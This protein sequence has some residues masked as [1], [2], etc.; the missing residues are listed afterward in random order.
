MARDD[1]RGPRARWASRSCSSSTTWASSWASPTGSPSSTS[2]RASPTARRREVQTRPRGDPGL[3]RLRRVRVRRRPPQEGAHVTQFVELL[4]NGLSLGVDL[5]AHR[6]RL[7]DHLQGHAGGQLRAGLARAARRL[8]RSRAL[9]DRSASG[10]AVAGRHRRRRRS[11]RCSSSALI[12]RRLRG[13]AG[14]HA[15]DRH[16][17]RRHHPRHRAD[18]PDRH[19][20]AEHR[21][22][23]GR[24][25]RHGRRLSDPAGALVARRSAAI[26]ILGAFLAAFKYSDWGIAMRA[27]AEDGEAAAL[28]GIRL[29]R[30]AAA[31]L[32]ARG[33][34]RRG[35]R[36]C[37]SSALPDPGRRPRR[38]G[39]VAL[40]RLPGR[41]PRRPGLHRRRLVGG[42]L[43]GVVATCSRPATR[44]SSRSSA[45][46]SATSRR[47]S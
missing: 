30:V 47:T 18:P 1:R 11:P 38:V 13:A 8:R 24:A 22:P 17:R 5:R 44:T 20:H 41:D 28:M 3:P 10:R 43:I 7:R 39:L 14:R 27:A 16:D 19:R 12:L 46:G 2:A 21:R 33:R 35:R 42:L 15:G 25:R 40:A 45:A 9:H 6:A 26:L 23:V 31:R 34:A 4:V 36:R 29:G 37:S 32:G